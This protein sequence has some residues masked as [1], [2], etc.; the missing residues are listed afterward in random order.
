MR[1]LRV[2]CV[3]LFVGLQSCS[4]VLESVHYRT[5]ETGTSVDATLDRSTADTSDVPQGT[6]ASDLAFD[7]IDDRQSDV[8]HD[9]GID[10]HQDVGFDVTHGDTVI[11]E[12][13][14]D[15]SVDVVSVDVTDVT[16][17]VLCSVGSDCVPYW[18]GCG[19]CAL[20][21]I[22][23]EAPSATCTLGCPGTCDIPTTVGCACVGGVCQRHDTAVMGCSSSAECTGGELCCYPCGT[24]G[25][26][27][28][29]VP[30]DPTSGGCPIL[31]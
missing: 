7:T 12:I 23:C 16:R 2:A 15:A 20:S 18:C 29:C 31:P 24:A 6:D 13:A 14:V 22:T 8:V 10:A 26:T 17:F 11:G 4:L 19:T 27:N 5:R 25:C 21:A 28:T 9:A 1:S 30:P 3:V